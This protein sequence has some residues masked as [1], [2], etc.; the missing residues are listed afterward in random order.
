MY[1]GLCHRQGRQPSPGQGCPAE[2]ASRPAPQR[3]LRPSAR[4]RLG[5]GRERGPAAHPGLVGVLRRRA[6]RKPRSAAAAPAAGDRLT[7][8]RDRP[9]RCC[10]RRP[11]ARANGA[12]NEGI[13]R[14]R[15]QTATFLLVLLHLLH[16]ACCTQLLQQTCNKPV[17]ACN[18]CLFVTLPDQLPNLTPKLLAAGVHVPIRPGDDL[19]INPQLE[20]VQHG[21]TGFGHCRLRP[22]G[23]VLNSFRR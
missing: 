13:A 15:R 11:H 3:G 4:A 20:T 19:G 16:Q 18:K 5:E 2:I 17:S 9:L 7:P 21:S 23:V 22:C 1:G 12:R 6:A 14:S 8:A 10:V